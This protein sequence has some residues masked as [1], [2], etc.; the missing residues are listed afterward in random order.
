MCEGGSPGFKSRTLGGVGVGGVGGGGG[1]GGGVG[2]GSRQNSLSSD[3]LLGFSLA[4]RLRKDLI[5]ESG[6]GGGEG[7]LLSSCLVWH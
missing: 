2:G 6:W 4:C 7:S 5:V 3:A 1:G